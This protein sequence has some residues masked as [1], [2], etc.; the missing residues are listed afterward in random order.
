MIKQ[1]QK[2]RV[3]FSVTNCICFDQRVM[4]MAG[5]VKSLDCDITII[6]RKKGP[7]C[8]SDLVPFKTIRFRMLV[9]NGFLFYKFFNLRLFFFLLFHRFDVLVSNDLDTLLPNYL[10]SKLKRLPLVY[11]S[12][13]YFT[14]VP[15]LQGRP[16]VKWVWKTIEKNIFPNLQYVLTVSDSIANKY[17]E[18]YGISVMSVRNCS[19]RSDHIQPYSRSELLVKP[20][21]FLI[22]LQGSGLNADRGGE[23][24]IEAVNNTVNVTLF[25]VGSGDS[26]SNLKNRVSELNLVQRV[27]FVDKLPWEE[28]MRYTKSADLGLTLDKS[29]NLNHNFSLPNKL[30][31]YISA[32]MPVLSS[33]LPEIAKVLNRY[34]CGV[35][36]DD[37]TPQKISMALNDMINNP[38][39]L[40]GMRINSK[41]ASLDLN[42]EIE[43]D[44]VKSMYFNILNRL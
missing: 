23:E 9:K 19:Y 42:W 10:I 29:T 14:G 41:K 35:I 36:I 40:T 25:V 24:L 30:F 1:A 5:T 18:E 8:E 15:E 12:H 38:E 3:V 39:S 22:I 11:D 34:N 2:R 28:L 33:D 26:I 16:F 44:K 6:G 7:C 13:E 4:K 37:V 21:D 20:D 31:D 27:R 32:G 17:A 43:S